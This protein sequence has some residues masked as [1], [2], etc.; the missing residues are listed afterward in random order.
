VRRR[1]VVGRRACTL[2]SLA[3][4]CS[5]AAC[6]RGKER[7]DSTSVAAATPAPGARSALL[8]AVQSQGPQL[9]GTLA[10]PVGQYTPDEF[11]AF[12]HALT[13]GGGDDKP[14]KCK[15]NPACQAAGGK[16]TSARVD[17]VDGLDSL[18]AARVPPNGIVVVAAKNTGA[19]EEERYNLLPGPYEYYLVITPVSA[20][21]SHWSLRQL[22]TSGTR[23]LSEVASGTVQP[24]HHPWSKGKYRANFYT[25]RDSHM[26]DS[27][28]KMGLVLQDAISDPIWMRCADGC[29]T[30]N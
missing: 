19:Y 23:T 24:C 7:A 6:A 12:V 9:P 3:S 29:C 26:D 17:A 25:C 5:L 16:V 2:A 22:G 15:G 10:K 30:F 4:L 13:F 8:G 14:R 11:Y 28:M 20:D 27:T 1:S 18:S 21:S